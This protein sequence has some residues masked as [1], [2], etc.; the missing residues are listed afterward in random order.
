MWMFGIWLVP[1]LV[2]AIRSPGTDL[3]NHRLLL[4]AAVVSLIGQ[5]TW[6]NVLQHIA[7]V[8]A[9]AGW[10]QPFRGQWIWMAVGCLWMPACG[11]VLSGLP[12]MWS[13]LSR[14]TAILT[15]TLLVLV[16]EMRQPIPAR[17]APAKS[18]VN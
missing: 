8:L 11:W 16:L 13:T 5:L 2:F 1:A 7:L 14:G 3:V 12:L 9:I 4:F 15:V 17:T 18:I 6:L 10:R